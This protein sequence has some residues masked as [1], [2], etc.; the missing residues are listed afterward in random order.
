MDQILQNSGHECLGVL[1]GISKFRTLPGFFKKHFNGKITE[2]NSPNFIRDKENKSIQI[3]KSIIYNIARIFLYINSIKNIHKTIQHYNP[4]LIISFY[5]PLSGL[6]RFFYKRRI[7]CISVAHQYGWKYTGYISGGTWPEKF[8][9]KLLTAIS[10]YGSDKLFCICPEDNSGIKHH[11]LV[12][13]PPLIR[14]E[15]KNSFVNN[16]DH[17]T[18]YLLNSGYKTEIQ[19][20]H[21]AHPEQ[22]IHCFIDADHNESSTSTLKF[23]SIDEKAF[24]NSLSHCKVLIGTAGYESIC[25][26]MYLYK[27]VL[28]VPV[29]NHFEQQLN[30]TFFENA[31][32][33]IQ[34]DFFDIDKLLNFT[35]E[36]KPA[37]GFKEWA[38]K[39][40]K[41]IEEEIKALMTM[42]PN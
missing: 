15:V 31:G 10:A 25:E 35:S 27:P 19:Q 29:K 13:I 24:I 36:F 14:N 12:F 26:A 32:A 34:S 39:C 8:A 1:T 28:M 38:D 4:D 6:Y 40:P 2:F 30:A 3:F 5:E 22:E 33:G 7:P 37:N 18:A 9:V 42:P 23:Y 17:L 11:R 20:W 16:H 21:S 41:I